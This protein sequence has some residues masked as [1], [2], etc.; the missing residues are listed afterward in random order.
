MERNSIKQLPI[1]KLR[2]EKKNIIKSC[3]YSIHCISRNRVFPNWISL[4][5]MLLSVTMG[6]VENDRHIRKAMCLCKEEGSVS[7]ERV[8]ITETR[9]HGYDRSC[10]S[11]REFS[12]QAGVSVDIRSGKMMSLP[13]IMHKKKPLF[14]RAEGR[15]PQ[16]KIRYRKYRRLLRAMS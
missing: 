11:W 6:A 2:K 1:Q 3:A 5:I 10:M 9:P 15:D 4:I 7:E 16:M 14:Q 13:P 12:K 8:W